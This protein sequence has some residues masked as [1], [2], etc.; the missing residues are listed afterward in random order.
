MPAISH[1]QQTINTLFDIAEIGDCEV[2]EVFEM[3]TPSEVIQLL[4]ERQLTP[5]LLLNSKK[6]MNFYISKVSSEERL[7]MESII[8]PAYWAEKFEK[9]PK[10]VE[11]MRLYVL[12]LN[13]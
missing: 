10:V 1:A 3:M 4:R 6:F 8:R 2:N 13:L 9:Y 12:E 5:W 7:I 11:T